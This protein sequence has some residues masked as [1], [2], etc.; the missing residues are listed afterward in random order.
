MLLPEQDTGLDF[1]KEYAMAQT[2]ANLN[3][4]A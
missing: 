4:N 1:E 2:M 3:P